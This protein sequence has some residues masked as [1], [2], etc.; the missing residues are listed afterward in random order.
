MWGEMIFVHFD[1]DDVGSCL[2]LLLLDEDIELARKYS[3]SI[4]RALELIRTTL[5]SYRGADIFVLGGDDLVVALPDASFDIAE[6]E[7]LRKRF[8]ES[9]GRTMSAGIGFSSCEAT[10][11]LRRAKLSGKN[12]IVSSPMIMGVSIHEQV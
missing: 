8:F 10:Q 2:E 1:G 9:C 11:N 3:A 12:A 5:V 7:N 6:I 4:T